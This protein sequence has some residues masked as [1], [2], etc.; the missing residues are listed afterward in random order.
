MFKKY[1]TKLRSHGPEEE[2]CDLDTL[3]ASAEAR[4]RISENVHDR[5]H[6]AEF[7]M[8]LSSLR[9]F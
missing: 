4:A 6:E 8:K 9:V 2:E 3:S 5:N 7:E 1:F